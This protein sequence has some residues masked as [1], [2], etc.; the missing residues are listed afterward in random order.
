MSLILVWQI[1]SYS[2]PI[3]LT[4][5]M[6]KSCWFRG[7]I[8]DQSLELSF[9]AN[10]VPAWRCTRFAKAT[11]H[12]T[13]TLQTTTE[14]E[15]PAMFVAFWTVWVVADSALLSLNLKISRQNSPRSTAKLHQLL[16]AAQ[17]PGSSL[18]KRP[19]S[20]PRGREMPRM[21]ARKALFASCSGKI[22]KNWK[23]LLLLASARLVSRKLPSTRTAMWKI[24]RLYTDPEPQSASCPKWGEFTTILSR[25]V[26]S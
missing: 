22:S 4:E 20:P 2:T 14:M 16:S 13:C 3:P 1:C 5:G 26:L 8:G 18:S 11:N 24:L 23:E 25:K 6:L 21:P 19:N 17:S 10:S 12:Y 7:K 9:T 15:L